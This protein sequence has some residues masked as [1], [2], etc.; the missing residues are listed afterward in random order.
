MELTFIYQSVTDLPAA[1]AFYRDV[2]G[3]DEAWREGEGTVA[4][5]LPGT[6]VQ[7]M[8]DV[9]PDSDKRWSSGPFFAV[10]DVQAFMKEHPD[11]HWLGEAF[12]MPGGKSTS[13][14][15]PSGNVVHIFDQSAEAE[16]SP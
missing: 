1:L 6:S 13:F 12:D 15:D 11:I 8:L 3:L 16:T 4:F 9:R 10:K 5:E 14:V 7:L 2:L